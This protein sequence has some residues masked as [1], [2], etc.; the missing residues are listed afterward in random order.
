MASSPTKCQSENIDAT[1]QAPPG[2]QEAR[3]H[4]VAAEVEMSLQ[5]NISIS[6]NNCNEILQ[7]PVCLTIPRTG[8]IYQCANGHIVCKDCH[9]KLVKFLNIINHF[10][11]I[12]TDFFFLL[13]F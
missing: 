11:G 3:T 4:Q 7:C 1:Q 10:H 8:P 2:S 5:N 9:A 13:F 12:F 6:K